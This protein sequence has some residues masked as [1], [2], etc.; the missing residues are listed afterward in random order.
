MAHT[1]E[2]RIYKITEVLGVSRSGYYRHFISK[3]KDRDAGDYELIKYFFEER[4]GRIGIRQ[5]KMLLERR[6]SLKM[7][8]KK[9]ARIKR[10]YGLETKIRKKNK[11][12]F[13]AKK[14]HEHRTFKNKLARRFKVKR[15]DKVY[16]TDI[17]QMTYGKGLKVYLAAFK[18]LCTKEVVAYSVSQRADISLATTALSE[19]LNRRQGSKRKLMVHSDQG[20]HFTH[21]IFRKMLKDH[22]IKQSMSRKGNCLDNAPIESF[23]GHLK[24]HIDLSS[25]RTIEEVKEIVTREIDYYNNHRPQMGL[26]KMPPVEYRRHLQS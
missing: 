25:C 12:R 26:K 2:I 13:F 1:Q 6:L 18:D 11:Y 22:K 8:H 14:H 3:S 19:A 23:F 15:P 4:R 16:S 20:F 17:T 5:I 21:F 10:K 9:I 24:D 7:N